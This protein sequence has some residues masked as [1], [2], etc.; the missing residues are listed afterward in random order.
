MSILKKQKRRKENS[1]Q[2]WDKITLDSISGGA[3]V[4]RFQDALNI[5]IENILDP[6]MDQSKTREIKLTLRLKPSKEDRAKVMYSLD[7]DK[8][9][10][11]PMSVANIMY[12]GVENGNHEAYEQN[13]DQ[14][15][16]FKDEIQKIKN[17]SEV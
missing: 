15:N 14:G 12:L 8:K 11:P 4:E 6:D 10:A 5:V 16:L 7:I 1:M 17:F 2:E 9:L 13:A 3:A